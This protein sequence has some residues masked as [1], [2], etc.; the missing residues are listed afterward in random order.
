MNEMYEAALN[1]RHA[2][3][4]ALA[5][6]SPAMVGPRTRERLNCI[7]LSAMPVPICSGF[8]SE[9]TIDLNDGI[10]NASVMPTITD[11]TMIIHGFT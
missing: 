9:G 7:E 1:E 2:A 6:S 10:D 8:T 3:A 4:P 11:S 5:S